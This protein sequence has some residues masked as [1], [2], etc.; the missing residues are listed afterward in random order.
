MTV[1]P[2]DKAATADW[3]TG[4][5]G[6]LLSEP[7]RV[8]VVCVGNLCRSPLTER[9]LQVRLNARLAG[10]RALQVSSAGVQAVVGC[11]MN[12]QAAAELERL[13]GAAAGFV[14]RQLTAADVARADLVLTATRDLRSRVLEEW[15]AALRRVFTVTEF[16]SLCAGLDRES[17]SLADVVARAAERRPIVR[18]HRYDVPDPMGAPPVVHREVAL[19]LDGAVRVIADALVDRRA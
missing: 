10:S 19:V 6:E 7:F 14:A 15:P 2:T 18:V 12:P 17:L 16:A 8:L 3:S 1:R 11:G 4:G 9:L 13:G 5:A